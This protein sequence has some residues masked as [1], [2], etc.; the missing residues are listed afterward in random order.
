[1]AQALALDNLDRVVAGLE[2]GY[3][4]S[5]HGGNPAFRVRFVQRL[6]FR[7]EANY[8]RPNVFARKRVQPICARAN[9]RPIR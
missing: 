9:A 5:I 7:P 4:Q 1:V 6:F 3:D 2:R 8:G